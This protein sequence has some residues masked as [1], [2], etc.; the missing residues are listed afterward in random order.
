MRPRLARTATSLASPSLFTQRRI[1]TGG[2]QSGPGGVRCLAVAEER[3]AHE[4]V[5]AGGAA[6]DSM[7][8]LPS[9]GARDGGEVGGAFVT[10]GRLAGGNYLRSVPESVPE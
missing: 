5:A 2:A 10:R 6:G 3:T 9:R 1:R 4:D 7:G 8:D